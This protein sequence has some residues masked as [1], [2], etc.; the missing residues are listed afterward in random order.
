MENKIQLYYNKHVC[1]LDEDMLFD[2]LKVNI[3][4]NRVFT[5]IPLHK[6]EKSLT[7]NDDK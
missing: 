2:V 1:F 3:N 5:N 4:G 6:I 7:N